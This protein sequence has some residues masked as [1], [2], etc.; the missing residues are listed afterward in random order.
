MAMAHGTAAGQEGRR[1]PG[2]AT[3]DVNSTKSYMSAGHM[4]FH[5]MCSRVEFELLIKFRRKYAVSLPAILNP[6]SQPMPLRRP[7]SPTATTH[8]HLSQACAL[9]QVPPPL[10]SPP[11]CICPLPIN[12]GSGRN[13]NRGTTAQLRHNQYHPTLHQ[14]RRRRAQ[15]H[16]APEPIGMIFFRTTKKLLRLFCIHE[17]LPPPSPI[18]CRPSPISHLP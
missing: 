17:R 11:L 1:S 9:R 5:V 18:A 8:F 3:S 7:C 12:T 15:G 16:C 13:H 14:Q 6:S 2:G 4:M 10:P